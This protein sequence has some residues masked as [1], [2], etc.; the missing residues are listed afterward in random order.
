MRVDAGRACH[1]AVNEPLPMIPL[2]TKG[3]GK[4]DRGGVDRVR[5]MNEKINDSATGFLPTQE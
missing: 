5:N 4:E 3:D 1:A 2:L